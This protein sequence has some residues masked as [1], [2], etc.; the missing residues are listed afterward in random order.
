MLSPLL[1]TI[2]VEARSHD[3]R[4]GCPWELLY[5]NDLVIVAESYGQL[6]VRLK[7][8]KDG[9][10]EK[11]VKVNVGKTNVLYSKHD[12]LKSKIAS[13]NSIFCLSCRN[14]V[15]KRCSC[16]KTTLRNCKDFVCKSCS[17]T[18]G[19][20]DPFPTCITTNKDNFK[21]ASEFC[22][23]VDVIRLASGCIDAVSARIRLA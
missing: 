12:V 17:T 4:T 21:V 8:G 9:Q 20:D 3:F 7:N 23:L 5:A 22:Y 19:A 2:I 13:A 6:K 15:H 14:W 11:G 16:I 1:F 18:A 10:E